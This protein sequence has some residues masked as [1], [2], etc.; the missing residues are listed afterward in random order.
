MV[1]NILIPFCYYHHYLAAKKFIPP[2][3][4]MSYCTS[5]HFPFLSPK[6]LETIHLLS[7]SRDL[8][9]RDI[10]MWPFASA[11]NQYVFKVVHT[12]SYTWP[13]TQ[14]LALTS[15][16]TLSICFQK[17]TVPRFRNPGLSK[18]FLLYLIP[19]ESWSFPVHLVGTGNIPGPAWV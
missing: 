6:P 9:V 16:W 3:N 14:T 7:F 17:P 8:P 13:L 15:T 19:C 2:Q 10:Y 11:F 18:T 12:I 5:N 4:E 1:L